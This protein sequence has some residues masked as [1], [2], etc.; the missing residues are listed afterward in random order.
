[1]ASV[2]LSQICLN[3]PKFSYSIKE[4]VDDFLRPKLE[5]QVREYVKEK[6]GID[7]VFKIYD[8]D[9]I[10][11]SKN[12]YLE[13][14]VPKN[15]LF[16]KTAKD[17][18]KKSKQKSGD[19]GMLI[20]VNDNNQFLDPA[21][22]VEIVSKLGLNEDVRTQNMQGL[23]CSSFSEALL[24]S[25]G[26]FQ[27]NGKSNSMVLIGSMY[28]D[29]FLDRLKQ[30]KLVSKKNKSDLNNL[31]YFLIFSD[32]VGGTILSKNDK[33][34]IASIDSNDIFSC[35]DSRKNGYKKASLKMSPNKKNRIIFDMNLDSKNLKKTVGNL[36]QKNIRQVEKKALDEYRKIKVLGLHTAGARF[37]D[38]ITSKCNISKE[39][40]ALS[41]S[42]MKE[43]GNTG[44]VSS[45]QFIHES[46]KRKL[47]L[48]NEK[49]CFIDYGWEGSNILLFKNRK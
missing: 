42:L 13:P 9:R 4:I 3:Y 25:A 19:I 18:L 32:V 24:N 44:A 39:K 26:Y 16:L 47:L 40:A 33:N 23:A 45:L 36:C 48:K 17:L 1:M 5:R 10:D 6:L 35:K 2:D 27:L 41:Y 21:P 14:D 20:T 12:D 8:F 15:E 11:F 38:Y 31:V 34:R 7:K 22:T 29:W 28:T 30:I 37:L 43:T 46:I 49:G